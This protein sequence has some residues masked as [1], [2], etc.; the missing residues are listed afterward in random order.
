MKGPQ[1]PLYEYKCNG[2]AEHVTEDD[3]PSLTRTVCWAPTSEGPCRYLRRRV[4]TP[5]ALTSEA[6]PTRKGKR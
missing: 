6:T 3:H 2:T 5:P 4:Y 1:M